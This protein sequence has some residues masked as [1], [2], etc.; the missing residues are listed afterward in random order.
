MPKKA[1]GERRVLQM[2]EDREGIAR[3][4][5]RP[6]SP[7]HNPSPARKPSPTREVEKTLEEVEKQAEEARQLENMG[8][9]PSSLPTQQLAQRLGHLL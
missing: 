3:K 6:P 5:R 2:K 4:G 9:S 7:V 1:R 8:R